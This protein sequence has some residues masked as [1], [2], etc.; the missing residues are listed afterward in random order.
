MF[1]F[2][3]TGSTHPA[4]TRMEPPRAAASPRRSFWPTRAHLRCGDGPVEDCVAAKR[5]KLGSSPG[6][7]GAWPA[8]GAAR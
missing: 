6:A 1:T 7:S 5:V 3:G 2:H 8:R 4:Y